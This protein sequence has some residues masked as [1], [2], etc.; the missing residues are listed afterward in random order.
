MPKT[1]PLVAPL[2]DAERMRVYPRIFLGVYVLMAAILAFT[3]HNM[4]DRFGKPIGYDFMAYWSASRL[5]LDGRFGDVY[6][7]A[8]ISEIQHRAISGSTL[9]YPWHYPPTYQVLIAPLAL[10][11]YLPSYIFFVALTLAAYLA[12]TKRLL[13]LPEAP[14]LLAA[15]PGVFLCAF[16]GQNSLLTAALFAAAIFCLER[17]PLLAGVFFGLLAYKPQYGVLIPLVLVAS[18]QWRCFGAATLTVIVY[19][20]VSTAIVGLDLWRPF[21]ADMWVTGDFLERGIL[22]WPKMPSA[23]VFV[24][25]LGVSTMLAYASQAIVAVG[26]AA[27]AVIVWWRCGPTKLAGATLVCATILIQAY[28]FDY[29]MALLAVPLA[30][31]ATDMAQRGSRIWERVVLLIGF[32]FPLIMWPVAS[33][34]HFQIGFPALLLV[35]LLCARRALFPAPGAGGRDSAEATAPV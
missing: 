15:F 32:V 30:I 27:V 13:A 23:F 29:E 17:R 16:Q 20:G 26:A 10:L 4:V 31:L 9:V 5:T 2:F 7:I 19:G 11:P 18:R 12:A 21:F 24:R 22:P 8:A 34:T 25:Y 33:F 1:A 35:M 6:D 3:S 28:V 14:L